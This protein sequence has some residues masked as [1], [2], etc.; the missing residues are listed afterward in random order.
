MKNMKEQ[1]ITET[2]EFNYMP[3]AMSVILSRALPEIDGFKPSH[4]KLLYTMYKMN[5]LKGVKTKSANIVGQTMKLNP[6][7]DQAIYTTLV[8]LSRGNES[9]LHPYIDSKGNFGKVYSRDM[10]FAASRYTEAKLCRIAEDIFKDIDKDVVEFVD[11]Y[12]GTMKEPRLLPVRFPSILVNP[13]KGIAVGMASN[14]CS[15]NLKE[16][17]ETTIAYIKDKDIDVMDYLKGPDFPTGGKIIYDEGIFKQIYDVGSGT[18]KIRGKYKY[19]KKENIIEIYE[20]PYTTTTEA[21]IEKVIGLIKVGKIKEISDIR[22]ETDLNGMKITI[23]L[24]RGT[25]YEKLMAKLFKDTSLE[26]NF[27][28]NFNIVVKNEPVVLGIKGVLYEWLEFRM[29]SIK[30]GLLY[31]IRKFQERL[32]LALGLKQVLLNIDRAIEIV[33]NSDRDDQVIPNLMEFFS[34]DI[35][36][37]EYVA[38]IKLR[39]I[40]KEYILDRVSEVDDLRDRI[41]SYEKTAS[42][43]NEI[44]KIIIR[45]LKEIGKKY[46]ISRKSEIV[47]EENLKI[48]STAQII[49]DYNVNIFFTDHNYI[50]K[51]SLVS[52]RAAN[53]HRLKDDDEIL[54]SI[55]TSNVADVLMFSN[56]GNVYKIKATELID[57]KASE[58]GDYIPNIVDVEKGEKIL[59]IVVTKDY[60]GYMIFGYK[61]GKMAKVPLKSYE[62]KTNRKK[63]INAYNNDQKLVRMIHIVEDIDIFIYRFSSSSNAT[64]ILLNT[65]LIR[66]KATRNTKGVQVV[67]I[68]DGSELANFEMMHEIKMQRINKYRT[69]KIPVA[70]IKILPMNI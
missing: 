7:G 50:K 22:D 60:N 20:I 46:D 42:D 39:N 35:I 30:R 16:I 1:K 6:H 51:V 31:D 13:N 25:D 61:N 2:L 55:E 47:H 15:F 43:K 24:K 44:K 70:G 58:L 8:R 48:I 4:R 23:D 67:R 17:C 45:E 40:N 37:A 66:E 11:N 29:N 49:E 41:D 36:Q 52:L 65:S 56:K 64:A 62:T 28:C 63:L 10:S 26:D 19:F 33:R 53:T 57:S 5:L 68:K 9:L 54:Q 34:I 32:H 3:Y 21:I 12:D 69:E 38:N 27:S 59:R 18:F 14:I